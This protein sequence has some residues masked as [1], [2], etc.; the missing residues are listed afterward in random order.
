MRLLFLRL[1]GWFGRH[2]VQTTLV[3]GAFAV[4]TV[5]SWIVWQS[6]SFGRSSLGVGYE[7]GAFRPLVL[8][9]WTALFLT[10]AG[11]GYRR[12]ARTR[13]YNDVLWQLVSSQEE[14]CLILRPFGSDGEVVLPYKLFRTATLEQVIARAARRAIGIR[15]FAMVDQDRKLAPPG[16]VYL[17]S[18]H[19]EW[20]IPAKAL[21]RRAHTIVL[22]IPPGQGLRASFAWEIEQITQLNAQTRVIIVLPPAD[23]HVQAYQH[24]REQACVLM[25]AFEGFAGSLDDVDSFKAHHWELVLPDEVL[26]VKFCQ[27]VNELRPTARWWRVLRQPKRMAARRRLIGVRTYSGALSEAFT[28]A[29]K[30]LA[31]LD[32]T[33]RYPRRGGNVPPFS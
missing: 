19:D 13:V 22:V 24:A 8:V 27:A 31:G 32:F 18:P 14:Y 2:K 23:V 15:T 26:L 5:L 30:E 20:H 3:I 4:L 28:I 33:R 16:P 21:I 25:A 11:V 9:G 12:S 1:W 10:L 17:R 6:S 7:M 29:E